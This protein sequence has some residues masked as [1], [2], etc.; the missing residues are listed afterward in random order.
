MVSD[1]YSRS[2]YSNG[3]QSRT[4]KFVFV[5]D[6]FSDVVL[7]VESLC[8]HGFTF[9]HAVVTNESELI[10]ALPG[11]DILFVDCTLPQFSCEEALA[12]WVEHGKQQPFIILSGSIPKTK[13]ILLQVLGATDFVLK[14]NW[15]ELGVVT[16]RALE[17]YKTRSQL[18]V[19]QLDTTVLH[20]IRN[21]L[22]IIGGQID[23]MLVD[24]KFDKEGCEAIS[25]GVSQIKQVLDDLEKA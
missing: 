16:T 18:V 9:D 23:C 6:N 1:S 22:L 20:K 13:A 17:D 8:R 5:E 3:D 2:C 24:G 19:Q 14:D 15:S 7:F 11:A 21:S 25:T 4:M 12:I 10:E